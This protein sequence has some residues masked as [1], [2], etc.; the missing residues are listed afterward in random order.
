[1]LSQAL[2][3]AA[4]QATFSYATQVGPTRISQF[5]APNITT[6][7]PALQPRQGLGRAIVANQCDHDI[8][9]WSID[10]QTSIPNIKV[11]ARSTYTE[12]MRAPCNG[13]GIS[14][15]I[16]NTD[17]LLGGQQTQFEYAIANNQVYYDISFVDCAKGD[18]A[19]DCPGHDKGLVIDSPLGACGPLDCPAGSYC[20][21]AAYYV[22]D[23]LAKMNI[24]APV[25]G[26]GASPPDMDLYFRVCANKPPLK[27]EI[28]RIAGRI[29]V[30][31]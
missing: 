4:L 24:A 23:P 1:M 28:L 29:A 18:S 21:Q 13:C 12:P 2:L 26:C 27:R 11:G 3:I 16:S 30:E 22:D 19:A 10:E 9:L 7:E 25:Q 14:L 6:R 31:K 20:P 8:W 17:Q 5:L 15:K